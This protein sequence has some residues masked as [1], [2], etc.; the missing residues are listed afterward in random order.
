VQFDRYGARRIRG[1]DDL[2]DRYAY[3]VNNPLEAGLRERAEDWQWSSYAGTIGLRPAHS[4]VNDA[5]VLACFEWPMDA[6]AELRK[7]VR[8]RGLRHLEAA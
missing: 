3:V 4:F 2:L 1:R 5:L 6:R 7:W 8:Q